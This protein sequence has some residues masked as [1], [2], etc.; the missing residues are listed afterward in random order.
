MADTSWQG[1]EFGRLVESWQEM[2]GTF[3]RDIAAKREQTFNGTGLKFDFQPAGDAEDDGKYKTYRT[4]ETSVNNFTSLLKILTAPENQEAVSK[5]ILTFSEAMAQAAGE[6]LENFTEFQSQVVKSFAKVGEHTKAYNLDDFDHGAF[7]SFRELYRSELQKYLYIPKIGLPR[8][9]H[10]RVSQLVDKSNIFS[11][12]LFELIYL[13]SLPFEKTNRVMQKKIKKMLDGGAVAE[14]SK[15][16]YTDWI[17]VLEGHFMELLKS[18][19]YTDVLN[20]TIISLAAYKDVKN[21]VSNVFLKEMGIPTGKDM[22]EVY[23]ELYQLKKKIGELSRQV[24]KLQKELK[25]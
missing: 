4:W 5:G 14:D 21:E 15:Q 12:Y 3:W 18:K 10:E 24:A 9:F 2:A 8:E 20:N 1:N 13:F 16:L 6:S 22:D 23:K 19:E 25:A 11:S 17:K 7:E